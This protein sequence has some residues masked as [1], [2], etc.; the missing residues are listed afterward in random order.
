[1]DLQPGDPAAG[2]FEQ[3]VETVT[4]SLLGTIYASI[5]VL[6]EQTGT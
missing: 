2:I 4:A 3:F 6:I 1:M 5:E